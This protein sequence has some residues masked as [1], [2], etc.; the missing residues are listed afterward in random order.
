[1][2][3]SLPITD[4]DRKRW[5]VSDVPIATMGIATAIGLQTTGA[6]SRSSDWLR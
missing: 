6:S 1:M 2:S 4:E 3:A 5:D